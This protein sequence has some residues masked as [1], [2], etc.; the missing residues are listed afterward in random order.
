[1]PK[2]I[3]CL[4]L[5]AL[6]LRIYVSTGALA[7]VSAAPLV[8]GTPVSVNCK[9]ALLMEMDTGQ[10]IFEKNAD[11]KRPVASVVK[12]MTILMCIEN[13]E[14]GRIS[15]SDKV[16]ISKNASGMGGSQVLLDT[17][18][19]QT[20]EIL[21]KSAIVAS[22]N[23]A[24][25]A[26]AEHIY[27]SQEL[28]VKEMNKRA[29]KLGMTQ[30]NF[31]NCTGL[32]ANGQYTTA[33]DVAVMS[34]ALF[35]KDDYYKYSTVWMDEL[36]HFDGRVTSL[37]NTNRLIR[38]Y[39]GCDGGKTGSTNEAGYCISATAKRS[40]MRLIAVV[41]GANTGSER[42]DAAQT[43]LDY[44]FANYRI[45]VVAE[46]GTRVRGEMPVSGGRHESVALCLDK[47]FKLLMNK[48]ESA[49]TELKPSL[50]A[51]VRAPVKKGQTIG[52]VDIY[53]NGR[54]ISQI[55]V[56]AAGDVEREG[57]FD[58]WRRSWGVWIMG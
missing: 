32:P 15:L 52:Y 16:V 5:S 56:V 18:E 57:F 47:D 40:G 33:R 25:V 12:V 39:D 22:A 46:K 29:E 55:P 2:K 58:A 45:N 37:T 42:F 44:G 19:T 24:C 26:I 53:R 10:V 4:V 11:E 21:L 9:S 41:L 3:L 48:S 20:V 6:V 51:S 1:M 13:I 7:L 54:L 36:D 50:P 35:G 43:M 38:L 17:G 23:D 28:F 30:T 8:E 14:N 34:S 27:G 49:D 31:V